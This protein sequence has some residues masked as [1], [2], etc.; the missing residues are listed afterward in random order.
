MPAKK[1][2]K[3]EGVALPIT[4]KDRE[5]LDWC[6]SNFMGV[7][8]S[9]EDFFITFAALAPPEIAG[10]EQVPEFIEARPVA[11]V[12]VTPK[13]MQ[14]VIEVLGDNYKRF[15]EKSQSEPTGE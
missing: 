15:M 14:K 6:F 1:P 9:A 2:K 11:K 13:M 4:I 3:A 8:H 5:D 12:V 7:R 10:P